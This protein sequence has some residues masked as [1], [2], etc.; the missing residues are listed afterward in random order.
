MCVYTCKSHYDPISDEE[1]GPTQ[2]VENEEG[3]GAALQFGRVAASKQTPMTWREKKREVI[4][5]SLEQ[6]GYKHTCVHYHGRCPQQGSGEILHRANGDC[7]WSKALVFHGTSKREPPLARGAA[8]KNTQ[9]QALVN[10]IKSQQFPG[11]FIFSPYHRKS[12]K[13]VVLSCVFDFSKV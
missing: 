5:I 12:T 9:K 1:D 4:S 6:R 8:K 3:S 2:N 10:Q 11:S 7:C 13:G